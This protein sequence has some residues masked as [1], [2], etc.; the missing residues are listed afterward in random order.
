MVMVRTGCGAAMSVTPAS[1][2]PPAIRTSRST[3]R[4]AAARAASGSTPRSKRLDASEGSLWRLAVR[5][6][7]TASKCA[8]S[9]ITS[10]EPVLSPVSGSVTASRISVLEP[11]MTPARPIGPELSQISRSSADSLR[12]TPSSVVMLSPSCARRTWIGPSTRLRSYACS[13]WPTSSIT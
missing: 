10:V 8:A 11:P 6:T 3:A 9:M 2:V 5:A 13:G 7:E 4:C 12:L 1:A